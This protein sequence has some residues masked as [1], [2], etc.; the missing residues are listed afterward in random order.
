MAIFDKKKILLVEDENLVA[1]MYKSF[2][3][4]NGARV[5]IMRDGTSCLD[6]LNKDTYDLVIL[7][8]ILNDD[9]DGFEVLA[10][11][12]ASDRTKETPVIILSNLNLELNEREFVDKHHIKGYYV[13]ADV[14][15]DALSEI[16]AG[17]VN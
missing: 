14:S 6:A 13:K 5:L 17:I 1:E 15:M 9:M 10:K 8:R 3:E 7:D 11:M 2:L 4:K 16:L 12:R